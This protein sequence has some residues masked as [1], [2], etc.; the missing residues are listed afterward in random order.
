MPGQGNAATEKALRMPARTYLERTGA[1]SI[2]QAYSTSPLRGSWV[3]PE[4]RLLQQKGPRS[5]AQSG[6]GAR[7]SRRSWSPGADEVL[8]G[9]H[10]AAVAALKKREAEGAALKPGMAR[11]Q[12]DRAEREKQ[13][14]AGRR[15]GPSASAGARVRYKDGSSGSVV[16]C[17]RD[18]PR[19]LL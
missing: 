15:R 1:R 10:R 16:E 6:C 5:G 14:Q 9:A 3:Y 12:R 17:H 4:A 7:G 18:C 11:L 2:G 19:A 8:L 13:K